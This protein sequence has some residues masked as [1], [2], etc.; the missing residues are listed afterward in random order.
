VLYVHTLNGPFV[1]DD[2]RNIQK[3]VYVHLTHLS[4]DSLLKAAFR[5]PERNRPVANVSF[6][7]NYYVHQY[8]VWG[9][10]V[11]N[12]LIHLTTGLLLWLFVSTTLRMPV[13]RARYTNPEWIAGFTVLLWLVHPSHTQS[14]TYITQ[15]MNSLG[16][17]FY[18]GSL[19]LYVRARLT[20]HRGPRWFLGAGCVLTGLLAF[21]T[22]EITATLPAVIWLYEWYFFQDLSRR[23]LKRWG[24]PLA[25]GFVVCGIVLAQVYA[26]GHPLARILAMYQGSDFSMWERIMSEFRAVFFYVRQWF[27]PHPSQ[28]TLDHDFVVSRSLLAPPTTLLA[29]V[30][31]VGLVGLA[32]ALAQKERVLSFCLFWFVLHLLIESSVIGIELVY[33]YRL[34]VPSMLLSLLVVILVSRAVQVSWLRVAVLGLVVLMW[35]IWTYDTNRVWA[36]EETLWRDCVAKAPYKA[37]PYYGLGNALLKEG[38]LAEAIV[39][40]TTALRLNPTYVHAHN[41]LGVIYTKQGR[42]PEALAHYTESLRLKPTAEG[43]VN[44]GNTLVQLGKLTEAEA[45][46][47]E[48]LRLQPTATDVYNNLGVLL[49]R[50]GQRAKAITTLETALRYRPDSSQA[51]NTLAWLLATQEHPSPREAA[52]A[53]RL[54]QEA[55]QATAYREASMLDTLAIAY[56][57]AGRMADAAQAAHQALAQAQATEQEALARQIQ[58]RLADYERAG[59][60]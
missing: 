26:H 36:S 28:L 39:P 30:G 52:E 46:Y 18:L 24:L 16:A 25:G 58:T 22:K 1:F 19:V 12:I 13:L 23:W 51:A 5:S 41:N 35:S 42:L 8:Q 3:N 31:F 2:V 54:A 10:H 60:P 38:Q 14:V 4:V 59:K 34:Y 17:L 21:G 9:Y 29:M 37:R 40:L 57:A 6:A 27:F 45:H 43:H 47:T 49:A 32:W 11:V 7:L 55:C 33:D 53:V 20:P 50:Q 56:A 48:A 15:R 44:V